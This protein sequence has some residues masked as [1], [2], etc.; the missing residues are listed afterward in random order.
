M[1]FIVLNAEGKKQKQEGKSSVKE[2]TNRNL[3]KNSKQVIIK[4]CEVCNNVFKFSS[5]RILR[6]TG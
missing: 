6:R 4:N 5:T 3:G 1:N 2:T